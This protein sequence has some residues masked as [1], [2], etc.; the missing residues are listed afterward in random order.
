MNIDVIVPFTNPMNSL[1]YDTTDGTGDVD[2]AF[3]NMTAIISTGAGHEK[4]MIMD[5]HKDWKTGQQPRAEMGS[6]RVQPESDRRS[7]FRYIGLISSRA[8]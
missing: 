8:S 7:G 4:A 5:R 6:G 2:I 1:R 3:S